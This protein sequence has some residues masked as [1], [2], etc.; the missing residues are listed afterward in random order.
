MHEGTVDK[1]SSAQAREDVLAIARQMSPALGVL[2]VV[3]FLA[4]MSW[5]AA[6]VVIST[7]LGAY[8]IRM[9]LFMGL[10]FA[11]APFTRSLYRFVALGETT[12]PTLG[13]FDDAT[14]RFAGYASLMTAFYFVPPIGRELVVVFGGAAYAAYFCAGE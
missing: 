1:S 6:S 5:L 9:L 7:W 3:Y 10:A 2:V 8:T 11:A 12:W 4:T 14:R 13:P